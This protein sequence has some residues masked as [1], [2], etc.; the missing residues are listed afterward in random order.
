MEKFFCQNSECQ[1]AVILADVEL[2][3]MYMYIHNLLRFGD[4]HS[5]TR[6]S[7][8]R[9]QRGKMKNKKSFTGTRE[10]IKENELIS[11][12]H[13]IELPGFLFCVCSK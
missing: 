12:A 11:V 5:I 1:L 10:E 6:E 7:S 3:Y 9:V 8:R 4:G 13:A 2:P